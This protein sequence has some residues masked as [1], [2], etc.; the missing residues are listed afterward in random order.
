MEREVSREEFLA[1]MGP[2]DVHPCPRYPDRTEWALYGG[3]GK[4]VGV[5]WPGWKNPGD[6]SRYVLLT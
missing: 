6:P 2:L 1:A 3:A 4:V 5:S